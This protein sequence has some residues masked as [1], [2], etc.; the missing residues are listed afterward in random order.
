[1]LSP[2]GQLPKIHSLLLKPCARV[3]RL[4]AKARRSVMLA[5]SVRN[6]MELGLLFIFL[7][8]LHKTT[9]GLGRL[10]ANCVFK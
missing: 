8:L 5:N 10:E 1:M 4:V 7:V 3:F 9:E 2:V 6:L